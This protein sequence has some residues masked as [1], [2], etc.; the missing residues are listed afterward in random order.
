MGERPG[1]LYTRARGT[2]LYTLDGLP[3]SSRQLLERHYPDIAGDPFG[4]ISRSLAGA[5]EDR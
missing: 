3:V 1:G 5:A 2:K 4:Y